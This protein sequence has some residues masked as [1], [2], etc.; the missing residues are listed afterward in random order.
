MKYDLTKKPTR[1]AQRTLGL[2]SNTMFELLSEEP[3]EKISVNNL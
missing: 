1:G 3:F 2:F